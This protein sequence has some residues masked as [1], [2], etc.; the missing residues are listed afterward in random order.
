MRLTK[1][2]AMN[3]RILIFK[4]SFPAAAAGHS[5][6][7]IAQRMPVMSINPIGL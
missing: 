6:F 3:G 1:L 7:P 2:F 5:S 4:L